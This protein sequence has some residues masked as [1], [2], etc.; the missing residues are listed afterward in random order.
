VQVGVVTPAVPAPDATRP[1]VVVPPPATDPL[2]AAFFTVPA[3]VVDT[4]PHMLVMVYPLA[5]V[6]PT[7]HPLSAAVGEVGR[8]QGVATIASCLPGMTSSHGP[9]TVAGQLMP[10][11]G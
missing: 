1:K 3:V 10:S 2:Y 4:A 9:P 6:S 8:G 11:S 5:R 7:V